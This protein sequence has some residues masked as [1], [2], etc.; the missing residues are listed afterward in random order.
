M[1]PCVLNKDLWSIH[2][3]GSSMNVHVKHSP[4]YWFTS[5][6]SPQLW[7]AIFHLWTMISWLWLVY[8]IITIP[9]SPT[10]FSDSVARDLEWF[11]L[12]AQWW[13]VARKAS[14]IV[15]FPLVRVKLDKGTSWQMLRYEIWLT[16]Q[17][18]SWSNS[19]W[20]APEI[21]CRVPPMHR[22]LRVTGLP[23]GN[24][25]VKIG[26]TLHFNCNNDKLLD[27]PEHTQCLESGQWSSQ[28]PTCAGVLTSSHRE[29]TPFAQCD[30]S[31][32]DPDSTLYLLPNRILPRWSSS[33]QCHCQWKSDIS[34]NR[35]TRKKVNV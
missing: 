20:C 26:H 1:H 33:D 29:T 25:T 3:F 12:A 11:W 34:T 32:L 19:A 5:I 4:L 17:Y 8:R 24:E 7:A 30:F 22:D 9:S 16:T 14:G 10:A 27:G 31:C 23:P 35:K 6:V 21:S 18:F 28:F 2:T 15:C 13:Y